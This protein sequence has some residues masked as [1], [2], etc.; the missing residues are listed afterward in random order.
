MMRFSNLLAIGLALSLIACGTRV[1]EIQEVW[2]PVGI[3]ANS[4]HW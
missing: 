2:E 1:P 3:N 4:E